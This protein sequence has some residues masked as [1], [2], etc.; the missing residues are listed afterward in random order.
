MKENRN[1]GSGY[2]ELKGSVINYGYDNFDDF[3]LAVYNHRVKWLGQKG[4]F[5][6]IAR[7]LIPLISKIDDNIY[8][9][10][11]STG[12]G[13]DNVVQNYNT[14]KVHAHL[15]DESAGDAL[16]VIR[17]NVYSINSEKSVFP[18]SRLTPDEDVF[19]VIEKNIVEKCLPP[20]G[21]KN[22]VSEF[23]EDCAARDEL[24]GG[25]IEYDTPDSM[26][27][28]EV[29]GTVTRLY[30]DRQNPKEF[31]TYATKIADG[32]YLISWKKGDDNYHI[33]L[34]RN[35]MKAFSH[36]LPTGERAEVIYT[37]THFGF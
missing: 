21:F 23:P 5:A 35:T 32:I 30:E 15:S 36:L 19:K 14:M 18:H 20:F 26:M 16:W 31:L 27:R 33:V 10:S 17:G 2:E 34:N 4:Y 6:G 8:F 1:S 12:S 37:I 29:D 11:W 25:I 7:E 24:T 28:I 3:N 22:S 9:M 13:G